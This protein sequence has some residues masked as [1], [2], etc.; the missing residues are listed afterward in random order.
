MA[1]IIKTKEAQEPQKAP[2]E[3]TPPEG[4]AREGVHL[5]ASPW[6]RQA[7]TGY[8]GNQMAPLCEVTNPQDSTLLLRYVTCPRCIAYAAQQSKLTPYL[9]DPQWELI[10]GRPKGG[11]RINPPAK[12]KPTVKAKPK[13]DKYANF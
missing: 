12:S 7:A 10:G 9:T 4:Y 5:R 13:G 6:E 8:S 2:Q 11:V 1:I 3:A